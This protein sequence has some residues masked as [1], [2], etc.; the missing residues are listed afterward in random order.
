VD[1]QVI[2]AN[3]DQDFQISQ[4]LQ[5]EIAGL[6]GAVD[7]FVR[8]HPDYPTVNVNVDRILADEA[9]LTQKDVATS[10]DFSHTL[11]LP[12]WA[13]PAMGFDRRNPKN[14]AYTSAT[15]IRQSGS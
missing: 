15:C 12:P 2:G 5:S 10:P 1:V 14:S 3:L 6:P 11:R 9:G 4:K 7:V 8:Q 13:M